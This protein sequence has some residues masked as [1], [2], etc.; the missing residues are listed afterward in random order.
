MLGFILRFYKLG[1]VPPSLYWDEVALGYNAYSLGIDGKDE[2]GKFLPYTALESFGDYKPPVYSYLDIVPIKIFGLNEFAVRFPSAFFGSLAVLLTFF[3]VKQLF[4]KKDEKEK[5]RIEYIGLTSA[6]LLAISPWH[7]MLSRAAFEANI[8]SF[9]IILGSLLFLLSVNGRKNYLFFSAI[10]FA[11]TFYTFN[12]SRVFVPIFVIGLAI[13]FYKKLWKIKKEV[14]F[15]GILGLIIL[16]P[17]IPFLLSPQASV[18]FKEVNIFS[19]PQIVLNANAKIEESGNSLVAKI[20]Y[21]RRVG[22]AQSY[23]NHYLDNLK[24]E[25]LFISGDGN[26][27]FSIQDIG[28]LLWWEAPFLLIGIFFLIRRREGTWYVIPFWLLVGIIPAGFARETPHAL[29]IESSLPMFQL[30]VAYGFISFIYLVNRNIRSVVLVVFLILLMLNTIYFLNI[31]FHKYPNKYAGEWLYG[32][33][34]AA[35]Y[36]HENKEKYEKVYFTD[37]L[38]RPYIYYNF[39]NNISPYEFRSSSDVT[40]DVFGFVDVKKTDENIYFRRNIQEIAEK[41]PENL[42]IDYARKEGEIPMLTPQNMNVKIISKLPD[43]QGFFIAYT[44]KEK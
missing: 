2:F 5:K 12:S 21:N 15:S 20:I 13:F 34:E 19:D 17:L 44:K 29:R 7:L 24:P 1:D 22:Y 33:K 11:A 43:N 26:P 27:R 8:S 14:I 23:I 6:L 4:P 3:L 31:M 38:G 36:A 39:F 10:S 32:Y 37:R 42:Y 40:R 28:Q 41:E 30:L 18:R 16:L 35:R 25:F 9:L